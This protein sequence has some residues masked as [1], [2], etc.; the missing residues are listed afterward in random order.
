MIRFFSIQKVKTEEMYFWL[1]L[2]LRSVQAIGT[3]A[4][5]TAAYAVLGRDRKM[6]DITIMLYTEIFAYIV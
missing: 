2:S 3:A 5:F 6:S 4:Y 1:G